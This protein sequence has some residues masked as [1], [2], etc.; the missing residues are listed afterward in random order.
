M[1]LYISDGGK[2]ITCFQKDITEGAIKR[3]LKTYVL[4]R[5][6]QQKISVE[7]PSSS[8][9]PVRVV[10]GLTL[11]WLTHD[12]WF[13]IGVTH[14]FHGTDTPC[15]CLSLS[16][17]DHQFSEFYLIINPNFHQIFFTNHLLPTIFNKLIF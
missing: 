1:L 16:N 2:L 3:I 11:G 17:L 12:T 7:L 14:D 15:W 6:P 13:S 10:S 5:H 9:L 4:Q 8:L